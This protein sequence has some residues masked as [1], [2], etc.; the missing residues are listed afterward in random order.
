MYN[1]TK[2][3]QILK[4]A[5]PKVGTNHPIIKRGVKCLLSFPL[6]TKK[7]LQDDPK[8]LVLRVIK[9]NEEMWHV[10]IFSPYFFL[11][12]PYNEKYV[13]RKKMYK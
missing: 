9:E 4:M 3:H 7:S 6:K 10:D 13:D 11:Q 2:K 1:I 8:P 12:I 5:G